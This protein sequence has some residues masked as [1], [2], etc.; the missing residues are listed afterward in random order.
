MITASLGPT[1]K[2]S[3]GASESTGNLN[4][5]FVCWL[6][7]YPPEHDGLSPGSASSA[8]MQKLLNGS[9]LSQKEIES[10]ISEGTATR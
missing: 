2:E 10:A 7:G 5:L 3:T 6:M 9:P 4:S 1:P 8:L